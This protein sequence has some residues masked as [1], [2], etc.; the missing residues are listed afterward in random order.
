MPRSFGNVDWAR[1]TLTHSVQAGIDVCVLYTG[2][3][4]FVIEAPAS[5]DRARMRI[6][7]AGIIRFTSD[8]IGD[9]CTRT[10]LRNTPA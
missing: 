4:R 5:Q 7:L 1:H 8:A 6:A 2:S 9:F 10:R 3:R